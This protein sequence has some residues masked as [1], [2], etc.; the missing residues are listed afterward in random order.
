M[1]TTINL[2]EDVFEKTRELAGRLNKP[3]RAVLNE[4]LRRGLPEIEKPAR[5]RRYETKA[6]PLALRP[7]I[8]LDN[9]HELLAQ[10]E[11]EVHR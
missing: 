10:V 3:F 8:D 4:A 7:G 5:Q 11:G 9:I 6:R 1:R 2:D